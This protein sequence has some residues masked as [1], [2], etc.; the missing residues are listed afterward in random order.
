MNQSLRLDP[1]VRS[2]LCVP[3]TPPGVQNMWDPGS[4][5]TFDFPRHFFKDEKCLVNFVVVLEVN[6]KCFSSSARTQSDQSDQIKIWGINKV[7][8][9]LNK[10]HNRVLS[11]LSMKTPGVTWWKPQQGLQQPSQHTLQS[12]IRMSERISVLPKSPCSPSWGP[13]SPN[14]DPLGNSAPESIFLKV[15]NKPS[16]DQPTSGTCR[17]KVLLG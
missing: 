15:V 13:K 1:Q 11:M 2:L 8:E 12:C 16:F 6:W 3:S 7:I 4:P 10:Y 14:G 5:G 17:A 9:S